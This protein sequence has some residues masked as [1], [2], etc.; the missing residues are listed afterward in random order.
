M[1]GWI[2]RRQIGLCQ[3]R[4]HETMSDRLVATTERLSGGPDAHCPTG[5]L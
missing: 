3:L 5:S 4:E 1:V 2:R